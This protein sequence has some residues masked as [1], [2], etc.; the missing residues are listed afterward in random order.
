MKRF[1]FSITLLLT[2]CVSVFAQQK[3]AAL[4]TLNSNKSYTQK[5]RDDA[6]GIWSALNDAIGRKGIFIMIDRLEVDRI[7]NEK[8]FQQK[9]VT[10]KVRDAKRIAN[11]DFLIMGRL[12]ELEG[13]YN[14]YEA[15]YD[16]SGERIIS[17]TST[18]QG[19]SIDA[20]NRSASEIA[21]RLFPVPKPNGSL[22]IERD[23]SS[24]T[25]EWQRASDIADFNRKLD[26]KVL[27]SKRKKDLDDP[28]FAED[29]ADGG[30]SWERNSREATLTVPDENGS[31]YF[32]VLVRNPLGA[33]AI[34]EVKSSS[35]AKGEKGGPAVEVLNDFV[36][37][38]GGTF[39]MGSYDGESDEKP[40]HS[41][42]VSSIYMCDH[43]VTQEEYA[44]I[45]GGNPS[46]FK[47]NNRPVEQVT[48][49]AAVEYCNRRSLAEGLTPCYRGGGGNYTCDFSANG[50]RL[51]TEAEWE[52]AA[53]GGNKSF[54]K[55]IYAGSNDISSVA[56][57]DGNS[58]SQTHDVKTK[59]PN[60][61]GLY[62]MSGN[63]WEWCW[64]WY[65]SYS[66]GSQTNPNGA[67][68]GSYR[69]LRGGSWNNIASNCR[70]AFRSYCAPSLS[71][72]GSLL[73]FRV[74]RSS[75]K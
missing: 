38:E 13:G 63:V 36:F 59:S 60:E 7:L 62:D 53:G 20:Y 37:V 47:G 15:V 34:Y 71:A 24:V 5:G 50:Y 40:V 10:E 41:V 75:S 18:I 35:A 42:T 54:L 56:W 43:E 19:R 30:T 27:Y 65:G 2:L 16:L 70:V 64:D 44:K 67:S 25:I 9:S 21:D 23:K 33:Q 6:E 4:L 69:V 14:L 52:Y 72:S 61:L 17:A 73:G 74:V 26:Y 46:Y 12:D 31:Y 8:D 28:Y 22:L 51:P 68:S 55:T 57:Y 32:T 48:W 39:T 3:K 1:L 11:A 66:S 45:M 29:D 58:G 49:Y